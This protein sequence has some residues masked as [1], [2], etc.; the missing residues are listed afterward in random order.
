MPWLSALENFPLWS[1]LTCWIPKRKIRH[2]IH[3]NTYISSSFLNELSS[4]LYINCLWFQINLIKIKWTKTQHSGGSGSRTSVNLRPAWPT[5]FRTRQDYTVKTLSRKQN[6]KHQH[7]KQQG[8]QKILQT[9]FNI[10]MILLVFSINELCNPNNKQS[11]FSW[12]FL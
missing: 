5:E 11:N 4:H 7:Q 2:P 6:T 9:N 10:R 8:Q 1:N 12:W 3:F